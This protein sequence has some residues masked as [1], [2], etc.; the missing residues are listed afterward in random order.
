ML[1]GKNDQTLVIFQFNILNTSLHTE[2]ND[3][4][5]VVPFQSNKKNYFLIRVTR[6]LKNIK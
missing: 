1:V 3:V 5:V 6:N 2:Y 4:S